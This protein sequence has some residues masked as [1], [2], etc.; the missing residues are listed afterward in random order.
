MLALMVRRGEAARGL[1]RVGTVALGLALIAFGVLLT[2]GAFALSSAIGAGVAVVAMGPIVAGARLLWRALRDQKRL[3]GIVG[4]G[5][6][7]FA[8]AAVL[9]APYMEQW[10]PIGEALEPHAGPWPPAATGEFVLPGGDPGIPGRYAAYV[11][12][13]GHFSWS[14]GDRHLYL[15]FVEGTTTATGY[16]ATRVVR[17]ETRHRMPWEG[18]QYKRVLGPCAGTATFD[19]EAWTLAFTNATCMVANGRFRRLRPL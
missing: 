18:T 11:H 6:A 17:V 4:I 13:P 1:G 2:L 5:A 8:S 16:V 14:S 19:G 7:L 9:M 15:A 3:L 10:D 12:E